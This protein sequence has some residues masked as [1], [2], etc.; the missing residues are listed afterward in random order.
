MS[1]IEVV[2]KALADRSRLRILNILASKKA[3]V[4]ELSRVLK[5]SGPSVS[6]H[7]KKMARA[8]LIGC[9]QEGFWTNY[10]LRRHSRIV[11][12][13]ILC[14]IGALSSRPQCRKDVAAI[15]DVDRRRCCLSKNRRKR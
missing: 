8:G 6:R 1:E 11:E 4:C 7:L 9:E 13:L 14:I 12:Q 10:F 3:C 15:R 5:I 2:L